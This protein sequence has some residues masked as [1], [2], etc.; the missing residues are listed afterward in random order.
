MIILLDLTSGWR[1]R[2]EKPQMMGKVDELQLFGGLVVHA[3]EQ[4]RCVDFS[5]ELPKAGHGL[6]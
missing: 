1:D 4:R 5:G 6:S 3:P 2:L